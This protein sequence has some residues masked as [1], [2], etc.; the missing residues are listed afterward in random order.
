MDGDFACH[1]GMFFETDP[2]LLEIYLICCFSRMIQN[3]FKGSSL[4]MRSSLGKNGL[5]LIVKRKG[6]GCGDEGML[7][8]TFKALP[9]MSA[10]IFEN[11][12]HLL[13]A[14]AV[15][16]HEEMRIQISLYKEN[17]G[18]VKNVVPLFA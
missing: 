3:S 12:G 15:F 16:T 2:Y 14:N 6:R 5:T 4:C 11:I 1:E 17:Q 10:Q 18:I 13:G 8:H 9:F 7:A